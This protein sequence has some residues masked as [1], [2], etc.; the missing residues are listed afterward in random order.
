LFKRV[1]YTKKLAEKF[2]VAQK[3]VMFM[4]DFDNFSEKC[5]PEV[6]NT[7]PAGRM[8]PAKAF[9]VAR[10]AVWEFSNN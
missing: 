2:S 9:C 8:W 7:R 3:S 4:I 6:T 10:D 1:R 5:R